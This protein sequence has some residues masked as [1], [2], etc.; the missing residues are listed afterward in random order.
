LQTASAHA[1]VAALQEALWVYRAVRA[2]QPV[3]QFA[4]VEKDETTYVVTITVPNKQATKEAPKVAKEKSS[5]IDI[6]R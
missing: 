6:S 2:E 3:Q 4:I 1:R 5:V